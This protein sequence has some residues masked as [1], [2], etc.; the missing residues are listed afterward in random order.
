MEN[1]DEAC[2]E[3]YECDPKTEPQP[4]TGGTENLNIDDGPVQMKPLDTIT[5]TIDENKPQGMTTPSTITFHPDG[6]FIGSDHL[7]M[8][9][10]FG[11]D[12]EA[13][14]TLEFNIKGKKYTYKKV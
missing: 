9:G 12:F 8:N 13:M 14:K 10:D 2:T 5:L 6:I 11:I 7:C 3:S 1:S 4:G